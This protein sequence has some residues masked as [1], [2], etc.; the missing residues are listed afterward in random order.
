M[1]ATDSRS[2]IPSA[3][4][5]KFSTRPS[6]SLIEVISST[7]PMA[8][9]TEPITSHLTSDRFTVPRRRCTTAPMGFMNSETIRSLLTAA[10][11]GTLKKRISTGVISAPPPMP[12]SPTTKPTMMP[13]T[14]SPTSSVKRPRSTVV[15]MRCFSPT[16]SRVLRWSL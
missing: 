5:M 12:V 8:A 10:M 4:L 15:S 1:V 7:P 13:A 9:G 3:T 14:T 11:G 16:G 6:S 2:A